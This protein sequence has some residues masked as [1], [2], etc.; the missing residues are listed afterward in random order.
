LSLVLDVPA[1][2]PPAL[3][4]PM[5]TRQI[6]LNL[7]GNAI[8]FTDHGTVTVAARVDGPEVVV[9]VSDTGIGIEP[10]ALD[11]IFDEFRGVEEGFTR[12]F[13]GAG[14]GLPIARK[15]ATLQAGTIAVTS[16]PGCG[17]IFTLRLPRAD[18]APPGDQLV[19][20]GHASVDPS[21]DGRGNGGIHR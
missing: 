21:R 12:R 16:Q 2:V 3:A 10:Q 6:L 8:K 15:L 13:S 11:F 17:S 9:T 4:D 1:E 19:R 7:V 18:T 20:I 5:R 14:L